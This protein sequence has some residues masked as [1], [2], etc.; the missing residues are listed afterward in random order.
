LV[1]VFSAAEA[2]QRGLQV[3]LG[4]DQEV[5]AD[6]DLVVGETPSSTST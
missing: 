5:G 2:A 1:L 3:A 6:N 4:I